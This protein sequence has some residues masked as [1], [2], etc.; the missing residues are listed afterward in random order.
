LII[1]RPRSNAL[2]ALTIF[3]IIAMSLAY[4]GLQGPLN[5]GIW[6]WYNYIAVYFFGALAF[7]LSLR[8]LYN[9]KVI[10]ISKDVMEFWYPFRFKRKKWNVKEL[11]SWKEEQVKTGK[12]LFRELEM[13][14]GKRKYKISLQENT[15]YEK[16]LNFLKKKAQNKM[17]E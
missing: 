12:T 2:F 11:D 4:A 3:I 10:S 14:F 8:I 17:H 16:I 5:T 7:L 15:S 9:F 6:K 13:K 1:S